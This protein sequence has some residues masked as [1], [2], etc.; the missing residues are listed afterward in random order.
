[1]NRM[2]YRETFA[3]NFSEEFGKS[4]GGIV[5]WLFWY[6]VI[7]Q[8]IDEQKVGQALHDLWVRVVLS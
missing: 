6:L 5:K 1:M 2:K 7:V 8:F 4:L 3:R